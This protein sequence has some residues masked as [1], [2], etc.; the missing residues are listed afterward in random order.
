M[1]CKSILIQPEQQSQDALRRMPGL[2]L[3]TIK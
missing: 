2:C 3:H 1:S